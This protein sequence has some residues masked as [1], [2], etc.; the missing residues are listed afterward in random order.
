VLARVSGIGDATVT[1]ENASQNESNTAELV[2]L[3]T[4]HQLDLYLYVRSLVPDPHEVA[5]IVQETNLVL[6]ER[7]GEFKA[8]KD[9]RAWAFQIARNKLLQYRDRRK[10]NAVCFSDAL[11]DELALQAPRHAN[12]DSDLIEGL[13]RCIARLAMRDRELLK[14]RYSSRDACENIAKAVGRPVTWVYNALR[15][16]RQ[17]LMDCMARYRTAGRES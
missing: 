13:R 12:V 16:I 10:R 1:S 17:E 7:S 3:L 4:S 5:E 9:F 8:I 11:I 2:Q 15:R 14:H 6:W